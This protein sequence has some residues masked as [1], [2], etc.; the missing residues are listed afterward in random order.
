MGQIP[1][2]ATASARCACLEASCGRSK[3]RT[4][5]A[6]AHVGLEQPD[7]QLL[8]S[9]H[10]RR[11][12]GKRFPQSGRK[13]RSRKRASTKT[14]V[15]PGGASCAASSAS[16]IA[17]SRSPESARYQAASERRRS[18]SSG[19]SEG[20]ALRG[21]AAASSAPSRCAAR[22]GLRSRGSR[23]TRPS[24]VRSRGGQRKMASTLLRRSNDRRSGS[25][26]LPAAGGEDVQ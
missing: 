10:V 14:M 6:C 17:R 7:I 24:S 2:G 16:K 13:V 3:S 9:E 11:T 18:L 19:P 23:A 22:A 20:V 25:V 12:A 1:A 4:A 8:R 15:G 26:D 21:G 5:S